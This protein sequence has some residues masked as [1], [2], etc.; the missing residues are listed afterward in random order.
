MI[1]FWY[2]VGAPVARNLVGWIAKSLKNDGKFDD[3]EIKIGIATLLRVGTLA[4]A[5]FFGLDGL[6]IN[7]AAQI[8]AAASFVAD[9]IVN[10]VR[11]K[12]QKED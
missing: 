10:K 11:S 12:K 7:N 8:A 5:T 6:G 2:I 1:E 4:T 9:W 3:Y